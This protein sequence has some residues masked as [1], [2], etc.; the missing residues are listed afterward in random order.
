MNNNGAR[1]TLSLAPFVITFFCQII[2]SRIV[3]I[4]VYVKLKVLFY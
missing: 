2:L 3:I 1:E 4:L